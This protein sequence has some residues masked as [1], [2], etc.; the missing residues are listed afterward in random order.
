[1]SGNRF[2]YLEIAG[3]TPVDVEKAGQPAGDI[4]SD[5]SVSLGRRVDEEGFPLAQVVHSEDMR[6]YRAFLDQD[7]AGGTSIFSATALTADTRY[8]LRLVEVFGGRGIRPMQFNFPGG[9]AV[10]SRGDLLVADSYNHRIQRITQEGDVWIIG[11]RGSGLAQL[12]SPQAVA[13]DGFDNFYVVEQG[14]CRVQKF[15]A[16]GDLELVIG[17]PGDLASPTGLAVSASGDVYVADTGNC[18]IKRFDREGRFVMAIGASEG[19]GVLTTPQAVGLDR[20]DNVYVL[21]TF[22][23][24][25]VQFDPV[26]RYVNQY[27]SRFDGRMPGK[28]TFVEPRA[29]AVDDDLIYIA[30]I[31]A[32]MADGAQSRGRLQ[33]IEAKS[34]EAL[35]SIDRLGRNYGYLFRPSGMAIAPVQRDANGQRVGRGDIYISDTMNHRILR[36]SWR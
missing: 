19:P 18:R 35:L 24:R 21:D 17:E 9:I 20:F 14:N 30:D 31:G 27:G 7:P 36:F 26:G 1:M 3:A 34:G 28:A 8:E 4:T 5:P 6:G 32:V 10:D 16:R 12:L 11:T 2:D 15:D 22:G 33:V 29:V 25:I 23:H 13:V